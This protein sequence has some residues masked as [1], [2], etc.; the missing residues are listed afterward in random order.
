MDNLEFRAKRQRLKLTQKELSEFF[1]V[2]SMA[3]YNIE[4]GTNPTPKNSDFIF[5]AIRA[6]I[7]TRKLK[8]EK[9]K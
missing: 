9:E 1:G 4:R 2:K 3:I 5:K 6:E 8:M 7:K